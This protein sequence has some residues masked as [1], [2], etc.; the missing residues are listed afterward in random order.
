[1]EQEPI[2]VLEA[3]NELSPVFES[4][5]GLFDPET[6]GATLQERYG[7]PRRVLTG[8]AS[9]WA[10]KQLAVLPYVSQHVS[11]YGLL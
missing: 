4:P 1:M 11:R 2:Y 7:I 10:A 5:L 9:P 8:I 3:G 6:M